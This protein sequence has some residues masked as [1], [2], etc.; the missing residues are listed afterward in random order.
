MAILLNP[1]TNT[2]TTMPGMIS[3]NNISFQITVDD[4]NDVVVELKSLVD[5]TN[6]AFE[7]MGIDITLDEFQKMTKD[8]RKSLIRD[9]KINK[10]IC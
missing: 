2:T 3:A 7:L 6:L 1:I 9:I 8:E 4:F 5:F 10:V